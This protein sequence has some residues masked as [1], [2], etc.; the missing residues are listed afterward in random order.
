MWIILAIGAGSKVA[1]GQGVRGTDI[2][3]ARA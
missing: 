2:F 3:S 1:P